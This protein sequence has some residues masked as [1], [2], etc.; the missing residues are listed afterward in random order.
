MLQLYG[1]A[2]VFLCSRYACHD[3]CVLCWYATVFFSCNGGTDDPL[4]RAP[5]SEGFGGFLGGF[6]EPPPLCLCA[7]DNIVFQGA[8]L[9][10]YVFQRESH[11]IDIHRNALGNNPCLLE[12]H[13]IDMQSTGTT[14]ACLT[15]I[16]LT[17]IAQG[18]KHTCRDAESGRRHRRNG[19]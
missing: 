7:H 17:F 4:G 1:A 2:N 18:R 19:R 3:L 15:L 11:D 5:H 10:S 14:R 12:P 8:Y 13:H 6:S 16:T 9:H